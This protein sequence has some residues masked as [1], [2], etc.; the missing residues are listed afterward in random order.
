MNWEYPSEH[1]T[2]RLK[3]MTL[4]NFYKIIGIIFLFTATS[5]KLASVKYSGGG[6]SIPVEAKTF[7]VEYIENRAAYVE[8]TLS[9]AFTEALKEKFRNQTNLQEVL[10]GEGDLSFEGAIIKDYL[11]PVDITR[12]EYAAQT[13]LTIIVKIKFVNRYDD[14]MDFDSQF[15]AYRDF[16]ELQDRSEV[17]QDLVEEII[18]QIIDDI[19]NK[20][21]VNW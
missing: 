21:V 6:A 1:F 4:N 20:A 5:C 18:E 2:E 19:Y 7:S 8:P 15:S 3:S 10:N 12:D 9:N 13:R 14:K 11:T 17:S 16:G